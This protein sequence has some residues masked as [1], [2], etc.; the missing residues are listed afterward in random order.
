MTI[1]QSVEIR[2]QK[3]ETLTGWRGLRSALARLFLLSALYSL[4]SSMRFLL[5]ALCS[6]LFPR[7]L[8]DR[9]THAA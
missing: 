6:L 9:G 4:L 1:E 2:E 7:G 3:G 8:S 5:S